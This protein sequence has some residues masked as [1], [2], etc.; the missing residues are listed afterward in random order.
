LRFLQ[1][2]GVSQFQVM[3]QQQQNSQQKEE[4]FLSAMSAQRRRATRLKQNQSSFQ[5]K[6]LGSREAVRLVQAT[7]AMA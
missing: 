1:Q 6:R 2:H 4:D 5:A 7:L 3:Q